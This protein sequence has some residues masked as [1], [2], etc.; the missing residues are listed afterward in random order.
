MATDPTL[1]PSSIICLG[2][3]VIGKSKPFLIVNRIVNKPT[4]QTICGEPNLLLNIIGTKGALRSNTVALH[5]NLDVFSMPHL[6][7]DS[8]QIV[9]KSFI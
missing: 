1:L 4:L 8:I 7:A 2:P 5:H 6:A 3:P 9:N